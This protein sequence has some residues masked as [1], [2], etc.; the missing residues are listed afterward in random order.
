MAAF[1]LGIVMIGSGLW[2]LVLLF[3]AL[4][5][6][7]GGFGWLLGRKA[8]KNVEVKEAVESNVSNAIRAAA[9][10]AVEKIDRH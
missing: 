5:A 3:M 7:I 9:N 10:K 2:F 4:I 1:Q 6:Q 8:M